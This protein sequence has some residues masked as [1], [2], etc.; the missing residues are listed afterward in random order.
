[1]TQSKLDLR[2]VEIKKGEPAP[3]AGRL[4]TPDATAKLVVDSAAELKRLRAEVIKL[5]AELS[6]KVTSEQLVCA[7]KISACEAAYKN[8]EV[9]TKLQAGI[10]QGANERL[11]S[12]AT[13]KW[14]ENPV[15]PFAFGIAVCGAGVGILRGAQ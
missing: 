13:R 9:S 11:A 15:V 7:A 2:Q 10:L 14:W 5:K 6:V 1:M 4:L 3:F 12:Q 8:L